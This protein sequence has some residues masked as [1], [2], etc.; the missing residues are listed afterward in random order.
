MTW[1]SV[2]TTEVLAKEEPANIFAVTKVMIRCI[3]I[4]YEG[5]DGSFHPS[6][7]L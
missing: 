1:T 3:G 4:V 2:A 6:E 5:K 7:A